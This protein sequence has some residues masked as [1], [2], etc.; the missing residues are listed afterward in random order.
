MIRLFVYLLI[1]GLTLYILSQWTKRQEGVFGPGQPPKKKAGGMRPKPDPGE[2]W[3]QVYETASSDEG[4]VLRARLQEEEIDCVM[5]EQG[6]KDIHGNAMMGYG[7]AVPR[8]FSGHAQQ[9][10]SR[11]L[12]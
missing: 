8:A 12:S 9:I 10:I 4:R 11:T 3:M 6:K 2:T 1:F 5:Y 7:I